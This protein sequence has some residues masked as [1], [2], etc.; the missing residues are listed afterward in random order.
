MEWARLR[1]GQSEFDLALLTPSAL[2]GYLIH[3]NGEGYTPRTQRKMLAILRAFCQWAVGEGLLASD[4]SAEVSH[5]RVSRSSRELT[6]DQRRILKLLVEQQDTA[7]LSAIFALAYWAGLRVNE[8]ATLRVEQCWVNQKTAEI[9]LLGEGGDQ[10][11]ILD[12]HNKARLPLY[13]YLYE[14]PSTAPDARDRSSQYLFTSQR[15]AWLRQHGRPDY[16]SER[17]IEHLWAQIK[18]QAS[19]SEWQ[20]I[21]DI[22]LKDL[23]QDWIE[24]ARIAGWTPA[25]I[26]RYTGR[27]T[28]NESPLAAALALE[29]REH[30]R[31]RLQQLKG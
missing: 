7:R 13:R 31:E 2:Q 25:E 24:R 10:A 11:R 16:L 12:L 29:A 26:A 21:K 30:I 14:T 22:R 27:K 18:Q 28:S 17:G 3:L 15:A 9:T 6:K 4:P 23:R 20:Q 5:A 1:A 19:V 8:I